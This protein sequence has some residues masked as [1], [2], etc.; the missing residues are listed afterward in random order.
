MRFFRESER[1]EH[2]RSTEK[3]RRSGL[4]HSTGGLGATYKSYRITREGIAAS[5][6]HHPVYAF[7]PDDDP[8]ATRHS[9]DSPAFTTPC[10]LQHT[11]HPSLL[12]PRAAPPH[13][14]Q[15]EHVPRP[16]PRWAFSSRRP[17]SLARLLRRL[18]RTPRDSP[19]SPCGPCS[20]AC[21]SCQRFCEC[22]SLD[23]CYNTTDDR[24]YNDRRNLSWN[25]RESHHSVNIVRATDS[26][27]DQIEF[28]KQRV[29]TLE[30]AAVEADALRN[31][32]ASLEWALD[33]VRADADRV[34]DDALAALSGLHD[35]CGRA[36]CC[37]RA[38]NSQTVGT[39]HHHSPFDD[40]D[41]AQ[42]EQ[43]SEDLATVH[44][45]RDIANVPTT[46][47]R[48]PCLG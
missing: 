41:L 40:S 44:V 33:A 48:Q 12:P 37:C 27:L 25:R 22:R 16:A 31:Q 28:L 14:P 17:S 29:A 2:R 18:H 8:T 11:Q 15:R 23:G 13:S 42:G 3:Q 7:T 39:Q 45:L 36:D 5:Q 47:I 19:H 26:D 38:R 43:C 9:V 21:I 10:V 30:M 20:C 35:E 46:P 32:V 4:R 6:L 34:R 1:T 24:H